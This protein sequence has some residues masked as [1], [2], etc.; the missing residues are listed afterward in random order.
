MTEFSTIVSSCENSSIG[1]LL[2]GALYVHTSALDAIDPILQQYEQDARNLAEDVTEATLI[3]F[4]LDNPKVS[5]LFYP[6][7]D[8]EPHPKLQKSLIVDFDSKQVSQRQ[9]QNS[10][11]PPILHRKETFV[12]SDYPLYKEFAQLTQEEISLGLLDNSRFIGM[13]Q[14]WQQLLADHGLDFEGHH[15][16]CPL[17]NQYSL[18]KNINIDRHLAAIYRNEL[19]R[20]VR[21]VLEAKLFTKETTFFD[22]GCGHGGDIQRIRE[23]GYI[24]AGW[25][26]Y[27]FPEQPLIRADIVNLGYVINVIE[28]VKER[29]EAL[30]KAW[31]LTK[32]ILIVS[33][34]VL[35]D[36][37]QR[38]LVAYGDGVITT[39]N[40]FQKYYDQEELQSYIDSILNI[41]SIPVGLGVFLAFRDIQQA[42]I[43]RAS[44]FVS[45]LSIPRVYR[46]VRNFQDYRELLT[47]LMEFYTKRGRLP[48]KNE[49]PEEAA[50]KAEFKTY[51]RAFNLVLQATNQEE[52]DKIQ[53]LRRQDLLVYLAL[54]NFK[55]RPSI[56]KVAKEI[57]EDAK[58]LLGSYKQACVLSDLLLLEV[59]NLDTIADLCRNSAVG[60][61]LKNSLAIHISALDKLAPLLRVYEG[62]ASRVYG[63]LQDAN[64]I[65]F[66]YNKPK[67]SYL[68][69]PE[70][71]TVAHPILQT[72]ME[73]DLQ[74]F[75]ILYSDLSDNNNPPV[76]HRKYTLVTPDYPDY[77]K[78]YRL[79]CQEEELGLLE[80][81]DSIRRLQ[82]WLDCLRN[83]QV[84]I[85]EHE[86]FKISSI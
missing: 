70:F 51:R 32:Q 71:D 40:T 85:K 39:R 11:N 17:N 58:A 62:C 57:K 4:A 1:K 41:N 76:L 15:V 86:I 65:K 73:I 49:L 50:I 14:Q 69:Y 26:P 67:I 81:N 28:D 42:E 61:Q 75:A 36:D 8:S 83:N 77:E 68:Y 6:D 56:R 7:F 20:P 21:L 52:W 37:R 2:P 43:F 30:L 80:D 54:A 72:T 84:T 66:Y 9:Y 13:W 29:R 18:K 16:V 78:F 25:A 74:S 55:G 60:K 38:G 82:G 3:K 5:Y 64:L 12:T 33:A 46:E 34:Q 44:C 48:M 19:S 45:R 63:R 53:Q 79:T 59:G 22:Y 31:E 35:I 24:S 23:Q 10:D 27:Y 47:P